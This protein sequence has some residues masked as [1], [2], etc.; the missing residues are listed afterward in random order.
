MGN[1]Y[2]EIDK[3][4][5]NGERVALLSQIDTSSGGIKKCLLAESALLPTQTKNV[6]EAFFNGAP[7]AEKN[8]GEVTVIEPFYPRERLIILG[9]GHIALP[10]S[11][12]GKMLGFYVV[13][14]DDRTSFAN[15][16]RFP[17]VDSV[18]CERFENAINSLNVTGNDYIVVITRGH[19]HDFLCLNTLLN[20]RETVYLGMIGSRR[21][22][23]QIKETL[24]TDGFDKERIDRIMTPIGVRIGAVTPEEI[25]VSILAEIIKRKRLDNNGQSGV[26]RSE[27]DN[28]VLESL[29]TQ[30][31]GCAVVTVIEARGSVPRGPG[32]KMIVYPDGK[33]EGSIGGGCSEGAVIRDAID[34]IGKGSC[35]IKTVDLTGDTSADE[36]MVC[37]GVMDVLIE[38]FLSQ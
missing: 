21:R 26:N 13:I 7:I 4:V 16:A 17:W 2:A 6:T 14:V 20:L 35:L 23:A 34:I 19:R 32:A 22:V 27:V 33:I 15:K 36:G 38:D 25:S 30:M 37:G 28:A 24:I 5:K 18:I 11:E 10:L 12:I 8:G 1:I 9:G 31:A 29:G 3:I